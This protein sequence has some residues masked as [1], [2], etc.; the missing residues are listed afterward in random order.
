MTQGVGYRARVLRCLWIPALWIAGSCV[1]TI[2]QGKIACKVDEDCP[3]RWVCSRVE[4]M[5]FS[6]LREQDAAISVM[7][8]GAP[9]EDPPDTSMNVVDPGPVDPT[10][11]PDS[12]MPENP[13]RDAGSDSGNPNPPPPP[14]L[15]EVNCQPT[16]PDEALGIFVSPAPAGSLANNCGSR[17]LPCAL[18]QAGIERAKLLERQFVYIDAGS[19]EEELTLHAGLTLQGGWDNIAGAWTRHCGKS[20]EKLARISS[21]TTIGVR[22][23]YD[24]SAKLEFLSVR[25]NAVAGPGQSQYGIFAR[26]KRTQ[27]RLFHVIVAAADGGAGSGGAPGVTPEAPAM[28][29]AAGDGMPAGADGESGA[30]A[31]PGGF[32]ATGYLTSQGQDGQSG[33]PGHNALGATATCLPCVTEGTC[34]RTPEGACVGTATGAQ[35]C[36]TAGP[37]G[38]GGAAGGGGRGGQSGGAS[39][40]LYA[41]DAKVEIEESQLGSGNGG[42]GAIGGNGASGAA[43]GP[44]G[45]GVAGAACTVCRFSSRLIVATQFEPA[46]PIPQAFASAAS[47]AGADPIESVIPVGPIVKPGIFQCTGDAGG[48]R[49]VTGNAGTPGSGGGRGG[50]GAGGPSYA[51]FRAGAASIVT[52]STQLAHAQAGVSMGNGSPGEAADMG[53]DAMH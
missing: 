12:G 18:V 16:A 29:C 11:T 46:T 8:T 48:A 42:A 21:P 14:M 44:G 7:D 37:A 50:D 25:S 5:C 15:P 33:L 36:P 30:H 27:L 47:P 20:P 23:D 38:C 3:P 35:S 43:G 39:I 28:T 10:P 49:A 34:A 17:Q 26:G 4:L 40:A 22:A 9:P 6:E 24:G 53:A 19:Y 32:D 45:A 13:P 31:G 52:K 2:P 41:W 51:L 1:P